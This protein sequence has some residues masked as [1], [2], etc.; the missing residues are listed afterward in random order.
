MWYD[1]KF[2]LMGSF[3]LAR[4]RKTHICSQEFIFLLCRWLAYSSQKP[5]TCLCLLSSEIKGVG[6]YAPLVSYHLSVMAN[7][8]GF[9][10][11]E[12]VPTALVFLLNVCV[13]KKVYARLSLSQSC[14]SWT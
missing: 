8:L 3:A 4:Q 2:T 1:G 7:L 12:G 5:S 11:D 10:V 6:C 13:Y 9:T 14:S